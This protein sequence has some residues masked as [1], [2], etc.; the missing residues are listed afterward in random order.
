M[1]HT[2]PNSIMIPPMEILATAA[3]ELS[4]AAREA[5][6]KANEH[7]LDKAMLQLHNGTVP[8]PTVGGF[9][10]ESRTRPGLVH[11]VSTING[12]GC[13]AG[14]NGKACWHQSLI[15]I[16][17]AAA[18]RY[19]MPSLRRPVYSEALVPACEAYA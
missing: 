15:E 19:T 2:S 16:I 4:Q 6:D 8:I 7:A 5:S 14:R 11:R 9:L 12:C 17:E 10:I 1:S 3:A 13:E 18:Q